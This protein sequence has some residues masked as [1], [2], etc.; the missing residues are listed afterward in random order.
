M[1]NTTVMYGLASVPFGSG[2]FA[3][4]KVIFVHFIGPEC[5]TVKKGRLNAKLPNAQD[6]LRPYHAT[7]K[8][9][10]AD[11]MTVELFQKELGGK[12]MDDTHLKDTTKDFTIKDKREAV[13]ERIEK[14]KPAEAQLYK[15]AGT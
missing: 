13:E 14:A 9:E 7:I 1:G 4:A 12:F 8:I 11:E 3:R 10:S 15:L 6:Q 2:A 5:P